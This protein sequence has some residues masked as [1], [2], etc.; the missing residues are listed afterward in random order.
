[1]PKHRDGP[2]SKELVLLKQDVG[3]FKPKGNLENNGH[4][5]SKHLR[6]GMEIQVR[7]QKMICEGSCSLETTRKGGSYR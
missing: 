4:F 6:D 7:E 5:G 2:L 3:K 1:M